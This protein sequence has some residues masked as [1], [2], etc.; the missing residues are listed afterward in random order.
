MKR[1]VVYLYLL[2]SVLIGLTSNNYASNSS[3][4]NRI[5]GQVYDLSHNPVDNVYVELLNSVDS[6]LTRTTTNSSGRF[7]FIG[8]PSGRY[9]V[10]VLPLG[11]GFLE[12]TQDLEIDNQLAKSDTVFVDIYLRP[13]KKA[14]APRIEGTPEV[15]FVQE[16]PAEAKNLYEAGVKLLNKN[17]PEGLTKIEDAVKIF[18]NYFD[19]LN[20]LGREYNARKEYKKA[21]PYLLN[22]IDINQQSY[23]TF[24]SLSY[25]FYQMGEIPAALK[26]AEACVFL[27]AGSVSIQLLYGILSRISGKNEQAEKALLKA[28]TLTKKPLPEIYWQLSLLYNTL[29]KNQEAAG[30]LETYLKVYPE[31]PE[32]AKIKG[33]IEKLKSSPAKK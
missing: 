30:E 15:I 31:N 6:V 33:L 4:I 14:S 19:A 3:L 10:R 20:R 12:E 9:T 26:A 17:Q 21:Y 1:R 7:F 29:G 13:D 18:P 5:E 22:A 27:N 11:K 16:I 8:M 32:K 24:Y 2:I 25:A 23:S 28:K